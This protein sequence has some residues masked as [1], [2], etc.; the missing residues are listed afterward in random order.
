MGAG[1]GAETSRV[2]PKISDFKTG[3]PT[4]DGKTGGRGERLTSVFHPGKCRDKEGGHPRNSAL[5]HTCARSQARILT[6]KA[7]GSSRGMQTQFKQDFKLCL[8]ITE[9]HNTK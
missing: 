3:V 7:L 6:Q 4:G 1:P 2:E 9:V 5:I 8:C